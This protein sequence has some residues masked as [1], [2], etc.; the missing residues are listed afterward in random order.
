MITKIR[1]KVNRD[2]SSQEYIEKSANI[3]QNAEKLNPETNLL[4][5]YLGTN[6]RNAPNNIVFN[7]NVDID[8]KSKKPA[9]P[10]E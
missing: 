5:L 10:N 4:L 7:E 3:K 1:L 2:K 9:H 8:I 6:S